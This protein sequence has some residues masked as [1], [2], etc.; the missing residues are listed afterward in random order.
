MDTTG[1]PSRRRKVFYGW[2]IVASGVMAGILRNGSFGM[3]AGAFFLPIAREFNTTRAAVS[4]AFSLIRIEGGLT[5]PIEGYLV[6]KF[7]PRRVMLVG[8][9][10]FGLGFILLSTVHT[11]PQFFVAFVITSLGTSISGFLPTA[12][13]VVH[14]FSRW[15]GT[16]IGVVL[17]GNS[18]GGVLVPL[19]ALSIETF[20][21][22]ATAAGS[23]V[24]MILAGIPLSLVMRRRPEDY[25]MLPDG[26]APGGAETGPSH[27]GSQDVRSLAGQEGEIPDLTVWQ[28]LRTPAFW[29]LASAHASGLTA[30]SAI[31]VHLIPAL[32]DSGL[33]E[34]QAASIVGLQAL[35]AT[36]GR[37]LGGFLGDRYGQKRVLAAAFLLQAAA[38]LVLAF[39]SSWFHAVIFALLMGIGFGARGPLQT[40]L[41]S[42]LFGR[43]SFA[44]ITGAMEP[45]V[46]V[47][48]V[49]APVLAGMVY[50]VQHSYRIAFLLI[51]A[52][53]LVGVLFILPIK[54]PKVAPE[55]ATSLAS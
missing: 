53:N 50:D 12:T 41:R 24:L 44:T 25:G 13:T 34:T 35:I 29:L 52:V 40:A 23:G 10:V 32:V 31:S 28:A 20:G 14:W 54:R 2:W 19:V 21:W 18:F 36:G 45:L 5:G 51:A 1:A 7:G 3:G 43:K 9:I 15:R 39:A 11:L 49:A 38:M 6:D 26:A 37:L 55:R 16:A 30:W 17:A 8:W 22:R 42:I 46:M 47:G 48:S 4:W 27:T 33:S